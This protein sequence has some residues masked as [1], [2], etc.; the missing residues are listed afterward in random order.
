MIS[1]KR[2]K[3]A[4]AI[5][6]F[7]GL[8]SL[9][10]AWTAEAQTRPECG[11]QAGVLWRLSNTFKQEQFWAGVISAEQGITEIL[12]MSQSGNWTRLICIRGGCCIKGGGSGGRFLKGA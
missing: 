12:T 1:D 3:L 2:V 8:F 7:L 10:M 6:I 4:C 11:S 5:L 9:V